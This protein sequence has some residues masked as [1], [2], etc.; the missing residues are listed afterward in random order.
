M[1]DGGGNGSFFDETVVRIHIKKTNQHRPQFLR[2]NPA[3]PPVVEVVEN[4]EAPRE[5]LRLVA[6]D[7]DGGDTANGHVSYHLKT[8]SENVQRVGPFLLDEQTG[9]LTLENEVDREEAA[10]YR[11][12]AVA[13]DGGAPSPF[14]TLLPIHVKVRDGQRAETLLRYSFLVKDQ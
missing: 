13:R 7:A 4:S 3:H 1:Q 2:P 10:E 11:L 9:R 14:E 8:G 5:L 12:I 6:E